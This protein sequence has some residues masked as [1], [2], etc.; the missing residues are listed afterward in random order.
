MSA[1]Q[2]QIDYCNDLIDGGAPFDLKMT[3]E[4]S[5]E[6]ADAFIK[7]NKH[8]GGRVKGNAYWAAVEKNG[9]WCLPEDIGVL[10]M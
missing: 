3:H 5:V 7:K 9:P 2:K 4:D 6:A 10:N 8:Y 1:T